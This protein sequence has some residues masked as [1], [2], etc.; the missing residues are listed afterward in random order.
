VS[1]EEIIRAWKSEEQA[2][3]PHLPVSPVGQVLS[4]EELLEVEGGA[5]RC[6]VDS[7]GFSC[8][9]VTCNVSCSL[10]CAWSD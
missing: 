5:T 3:E 8:G 6:G 9:G 2:L 7:C 1:L 4:E 10:S